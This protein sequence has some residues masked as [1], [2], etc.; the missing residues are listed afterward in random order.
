M[1]KCKVF[2]GSFVSVVVFLFSLSVANS[3]SP[4]NRPLTLPSLNE[5]VIGLEE[6]IRERSRLNERYTEAARA[7]MERRLDGM[8]EFRETL[9]DQASRFITR[10][11][12]DLTVSKI[13][14]D[15]D[16]LFKTTDQQSRSIL[17]VLLV[18]VIGLLFGVA[19]LL[20]AIRETYKTSANTIE[21]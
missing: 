11:E 20:L 3:E 2:I 9:R 15:S 8:N 17:L 10:Q 13:R 21:R 4:D 14:T 12:V 19:A 6:L 1:K 16:L 5:R 7:A 18:A